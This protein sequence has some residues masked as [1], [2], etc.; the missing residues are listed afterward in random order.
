MITSKAETL[1]YL[2]PL[3]KKSKIE[4]IFY[5]SVQDWRQNQHQIMTKISKIFQADIIIRSS[6]VG[7]DSL[8][9]SQAGVYTSVLNVNSKNK[10]KI[11]SGV[12][13]VIKSYTTK[14]NFSNTNRKIKPYK[15]HSIA[16]QKILLDDNQILVQRQ[17]KSIFISGV[18]LSRD[19][20]SG[21]PYFIINYEQ[22]NSTDS[23]TK[24]ASNNVI[25]IYRFTAKTKIPQQWKKLIDGMIELEKILKNDKLDVEF[26]INKKNEIIIFQVRVLTQL[27]GQDYT[28][29][30]KTVKRKLEILSKSLINKEKNSVLF[31][32]MADWNP[33]EIIGTNPNP[34]SYSLYD[35]L[36]MNYSWYK[37]R[38]NLGYKKPISEKLMSKIGNKPYV[39]L[40]NSFSSFFPYSFSETT[41]KKLVRYYAKKISSNP[42]LHDKIEFFI[43]FSCFDLSVPSR[44]NELVRYGFTEKEI[45][46][47]QNQLVDFTNNILL[48]LYPRLFRSTFLFA[49]E[50]ETLSKLYS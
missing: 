49:V 30:D 32:D 22:D 42:Y 23:V 16:R 34:L 40:E 1:R 50:S 39:N 44:L 24:G 18:I 25:K 45:I 5:F 35:Y 6:A 47:I 19:P 38:T 29:T 2:R 28:L 17:T 4:K 9:S 43:I 26:A 31:S 14:N 48:K 33:S 41:I 11:R 3:I 21:S 10:S 27:F 7:E 37:G 8:I 15:L 46:L 13:Q 20:N 12:N 36:I